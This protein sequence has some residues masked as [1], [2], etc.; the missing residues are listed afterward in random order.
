MKKSLLIGCALSALLLNACSKFDAVRPDIAA[1]SNPSRLDEIAY[2]NILR[3]AFIKYE[4]RPGQWKIDDKAFAPPPA[5]AAPPPPPPPA[6]QKKA[7]A[8]EEP[9]TQPASVDLND[10]QNQIVTQ[11][12]LCYDG[13]GLK[14]FKS[15]LG[16]GLHNSAGKEEF[17]G[18]GPDENNEC[19]TYKA[20]QRPNFDNVDQLNNKE[21]QLRLLEMQ[22]Y[23]AAGFGLTDIYCN[24]FFTSASASQQNRQFFQDLNTGVDTLVGSVLALSGAGTTAIGIT[25][26]GFGLIGDG[27]Q[28]FDAAYLIAPD[29]GAV[30]K[31]LEA[32]QAE[33]RAPYFA[34]DNK[35]KANI[36]PRS[37]P[38]A[39]GIIERYASLCSFTG[40]RQL[41]NRSITDETSDIETELLRFTR[42]DRV[43][44]N[45][46]DGTEESTDTG[47]SGSGNSGSGNSETKAS[48]ENTDGNKDAQPTIL[49]TPIG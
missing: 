41:I 34:G 24:R 8:E 36:F 30:Q 17:L 16:E 2:I 42:P 35:T 31:L 37:Y 5:L 45:K 32:A 14:R 12:G 40:M 39:R 21:S 33:F 7:A 47:N 28:G 9:A 27:I 11:S 18:N 38:A 19:I 26:S 23:L 10:L 1:K 13:S 29:L 22:T 46:K 49:S 15:K 20:Y 3:S 44:G 25:N 4:K 43:T 48:D 6:G